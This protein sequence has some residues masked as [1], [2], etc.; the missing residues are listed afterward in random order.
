M[1]DTFIILR[2]ISFN[3]DKFIIRAWASESFPF[4]IELQKCMQT[5]STDIVYSGKKLKRKIC[6]NDISLPTNFKHVDHIGWSG[7]KRIDSD[8]DNENTQKVHNSNNK[9]YDN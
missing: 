7:T 2:M 5:Q 4:L 8:N 9:Y 3:D 1:Y 6:K